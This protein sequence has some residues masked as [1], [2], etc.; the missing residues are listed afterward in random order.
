MSQAVWEEIQA[1]LARPKFDRYVTL[2]ERQL[3]LIGLFTTVEFIDV[4]E[5][6]VACRD[7]KDNAILELAVSGRARTIITGDQ[8]LLVLN[9][10]RGITIL[11]VRQFC[12]QV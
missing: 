9:P 3:F 10:F 12:E 4:E 11:T 6:V 2:G 1:V 8:D 5:T 7:P